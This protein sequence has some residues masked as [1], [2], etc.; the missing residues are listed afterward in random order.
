MPAGVVK[1]GV[2][3]AAVLIIGNE[4]LSGRTRDANLSFLGERLNDL[5]I[6]LLEAR[7]VPDDE[8]AIVEA[9]NALRAAHDYV[10]TTGGI[11][12]THDDITAEAVAKAFGLP[13]DVNPEARTILES[14]YPP[15]QLNERRLRMART[16]EGARLV[17]NPVSGAPGFQI[18]NVFVLAGI[19]SIAQAMFE[20]LRDRLTGGDPLLS[21]A[22][23]L[24]TP[25]SVL[26]PGFEALQARYPD[27]EMGSYPFNRGGRFGSTLVLRSSERERLAEAAEGLK[28]LAAELG[29]EIADERGVLAGDEG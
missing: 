24:Y 28:A 9:L 7:V 2:V 12:P 19:P 3:T 17:E 20:S 8:A 14:F 25:E 18:E 11:G 5:G 23:S 10:F 4:I 1:A 6:R 16:P 26:A 15:G 29:S 21:H 27:I 22:L 13:I